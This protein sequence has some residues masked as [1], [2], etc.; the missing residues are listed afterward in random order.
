M[1]KTPVITAR[2]DTQ[3]VVLLD[4]LAAGCDRSLA[5]LM[6][7]AVNR[8]IENEVELRDFLQVGIEQANHGDTLSHDEIDAWY[9]SRVASRTKPIPAVLPRFA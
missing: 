5:Y 8:Y 6:S 2:L 7:K 1:S 3:T 9:E 4:R